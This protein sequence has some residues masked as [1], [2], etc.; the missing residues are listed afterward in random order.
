[1]SDWSGDVEALAELVRIA[2]YESRRKAKRYLHDCGVTHCTGQELDEVLAMIRKRRDSDDIADMAERMQAAKMQ[3]AR[4]RASAERRATRDDLP[5]WLIGETPEQGR[6]FIVHLCPGG[7]WSFA[8][9]VFDEESDAPGGLESYRLDG[10][11]VLSN[12]TWLEDRPPDADRAALMKEARRQLRM[13][14]QGLD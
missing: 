6:T 2:R 14:D 12:L 3:A 10:G 7:A 5:E 8:G 1:M 11:Q 4:E 9:E 13:Y